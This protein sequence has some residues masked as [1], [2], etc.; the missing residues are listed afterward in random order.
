MRSLLKLL[1]AA[2]TLVLFLFSGCAFLPEEEEEIALPYAAPSIPDY[3]LH[4]IKE[5]G[6]E[7]TFTG[8]G[9]VVSVSRDNVVVEV[10]TARYT[11]LY[12]G[13]TLKCTF[14]DFEYTGTIIYTSAEETKNPEDYGLHSGVSGIGV[15][16]KNVPRGISEGATVSVYALLAS[17]SG[18]L[19]VPTSAVYEY[20]GKKYV[21]VWDGLV[22][23]EREVELGIKSASFYEVISGLSVGEQV[24]C[25]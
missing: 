15:R 10:P 11:E 22:R 1:T 20:N 18:I 8:I 14:K 6:V 23:V 21:Y 25:R 4:T 24:T 9:N 3:K 7:S 17:K 16:I 12:S 19:T 2:A 13:M 5:S